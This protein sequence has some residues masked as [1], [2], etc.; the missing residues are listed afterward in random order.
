MLPEQISDI[1]NIETVNGYLFYTWYINR[2]IFN[3][4]DG[5]KSRDNRIIYKVCY[6]NSLF[7][8]SLIS[9]LLGM[10]LALF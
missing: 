10:L 6:N 5:L 2:S 7:L 1:L 4:Q 3:T 8:W 9:M